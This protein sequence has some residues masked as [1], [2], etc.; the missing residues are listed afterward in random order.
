MI[1]DCFHFPSPYNILN[2]NSIDSHLEERES[3]S[4]NR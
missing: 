2:E 1:L 4:E 3:Y